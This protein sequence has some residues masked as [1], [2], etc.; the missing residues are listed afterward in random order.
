ME[1]VPGFAQLLQG[2]A[3]TITSPTFESFVTMVTGWVFASRR[4]VTRM[5]LAAGTRADIPS[6][7]LRR[8]LVARCRGLG[9]VGS[10]RTVLG[11]QDLVGIG[12]YTGSQT[13]L[14]NV[15]HRHA[16]RSSSFQPQ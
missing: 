14:E 10:D 3:V 8:T 11:R 12:R 15:W 4:T 6:T 13:W 1:L 16:S 5:I 9:G 7:L 2:F